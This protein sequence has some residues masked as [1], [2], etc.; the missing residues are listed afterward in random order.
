MFLLVVSYGLFL[1][2][3]DVLFCLLSS[4]R[5]IACDDGNYR[6]WPESISFS[7]KNHQMFLRKGTIT[8]NTYYIMALCLKLCTGLKILWLHIFED[9]IWN[10]Y[11]WKNQTQTLSFGTHNTRW[12][13]NNRQ[14]HISKHKMTTE[15]SAVKRYPVLWEL[16]TRRFVLFW[17]WASCDA[18][19][20]IFR[21]TLKYLLGRAWERTIQEKGTT[22]SKTLRQERNNVFFIINFINCQEICV[23]CVDLGKFRWCKLRRVLCKIIFIWDN[24]WTLNCI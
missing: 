7:L 6:I 9:L 2:N 21:K 12:E 11:C 14:N 5:N 24:Y 4:K 20:E 19:T 23:W 15:I 8:A 16:I 18:W 10:K 17:R 3:C 1:F 22:N 13:T